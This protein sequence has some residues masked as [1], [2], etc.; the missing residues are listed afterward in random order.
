MYINLGNNMQHAHVVRDS[1]NMHT[2]VFT[3]VIR[4]IKIGQS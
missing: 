2:Y 1:K 4:V 3:S